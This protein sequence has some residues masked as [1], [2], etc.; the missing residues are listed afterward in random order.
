MIS[1]LFAVPLLA[2]AASAF[3]VPPRMPPRDYCTHDRSFVAFRAALRAAVARRDAAFILRIA[4]DDIRYSYGDD[5]PPGPAGF[6]Q[7]WEL[8]HP[9]TSPLWRELEAA[10]RL[11]CTPNEGPEFVIPAMNQ[12]GD[13]DMDTDYGTLMVAVRPGAALRTGPS[14]SSR[15]IARLRWDVVT[16]EDRNS[17][18][19]WVRARLANGRRGYVRRSLLRG[20]NDYCA[21][22][23][24][25]DGRWR[26]ISFMGLD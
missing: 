18:A 25:Q 5:D 13:E 14:D 22:F 17:R 26:M 10:L 7:A 12:V 21:V 24:K 19:P 1:R 3:A 2:M 20:F 9:A 23:A 16:L 6:A 8:D 4:G 11:G 15:R